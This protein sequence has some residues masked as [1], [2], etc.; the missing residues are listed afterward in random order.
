MEYLGKITRL[1]ERLDISQYKKK[2]P[3]I[4]MGLLCQII[5]DCLE[6]GR[7]VVFRGSRFSSFCFQVRQI[8]TSFS[9]PNAVEGYDLTAVNYRHAGEQPL[10]FC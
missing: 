10:I 4:F 7:L 2:Y 6:L 8:L 1:N 9:D 3:A 5:Y